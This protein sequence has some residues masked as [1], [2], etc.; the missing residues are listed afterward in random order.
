MTL[1]PNV[2]VP[3]HT[4]PAIAA[5]LD[6]K[7]VIKL[8]D[9]RG[10]ETTVYYLTGDQKHIVAAISSIS[11]VPPQ[12][13]ATTQPPAPSKPP[14]GP[15]TTFTPT[16]YPE[17]KGA[18]D[19]PIGYVGP[20]GPVYF[21]NGRMPPGYALGPNNTIETYIKTTTVPPQNVATTQ[22]QQQSHPQQPAP[23]KPP[24]TTFT[25][26]SYPEIKDAY[27]APIGYV[28]PQGPVYFPNGQMP[29]GYSTG[30]NNTIETYIKS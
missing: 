28:G 23:S 1:D 7:P 26:T 9:V 15:V 8:T 21:P 10:N 27:G 4:G 17:I 3:P 25:P 5:V 11:T 16:S 20:Q 19:V 18:G 14:A 30:P 6:G 29:P 22:P 12:N 13:V 2:P 24:A